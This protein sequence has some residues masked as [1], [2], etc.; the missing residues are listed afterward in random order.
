VETVSTGPI[1]WAVAEL[2]LPGQ[3]ES[4]DRYLVTPT[5][6][7]ALVAA[8]DGLGTVPRPPRRRKLP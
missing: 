2:L 6:D 3:T 1:E 8:V 7:G 5:P 4:G